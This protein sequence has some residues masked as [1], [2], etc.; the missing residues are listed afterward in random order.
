MVASTRKKVRVIG[1]E[2][3]VDKDG[4]IR[5]FQVIDIEERD[6]NF[7]KIWLGHIVQSLDII[8]NQKTKLAFWL[9]DQMDRENK[10]CMTLRQMSDK[11]CISLETVRV[12]IKALI[13]SNFLVRHNMGVYK[14]NPDC[15]FAGGKNA[16]MDVLLKYHGSEAQQT[17]LFDDN[18]ESQVGA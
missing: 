11:S 15:I 9:L 18:R 12:T 6:A 13:E 16:R 4:E 10:V 8:G 1:T 2:Q 5:D 7:H 17:T 3:Y 14:I